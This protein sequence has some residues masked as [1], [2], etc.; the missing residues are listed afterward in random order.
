MT[1]HDHDFAR[2]VERLYATF[3]GYRLE[4]P[5]PG[6]ACCVFPED[7]APLVSAPLRAMSS[8]ALEKFARKSISTWG[9]VED[10][11]HFL[12]RLLELEARGPADATTSVA[13]KLIY[14]S[15]RTWPAAEQGAIAAYYQS[16][17][18]SLLSQTAPERP[19]SDVLEDAV[20]LGIDMTAFLDAWTR[21][22]G[23][24]SAVLQ[25]A[26]LT[27]ELYSFS[28]WKVL[29][30]GS[31]HEGSMVWQQ[32]RAWLLDPTNEA[33]LVDAYLTRK[34]GSTA[35]SDEQLREI[36]TA[37]DHFAMRVYQLGRAA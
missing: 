36:E 9:G 8:D 32:L 31:R 27:G 7:Q 23:E 2:A 15:W 28:L 19:L 24:A 12:P 4:Q 26:R 11:K 25:F 10:Y 13:A 6:C 18:A 20:T 33:V 30:V 3:A 21:L 16:L 17:A 1:D 34:A 35:F 37:A 22:K 14:A 5:I 29:A